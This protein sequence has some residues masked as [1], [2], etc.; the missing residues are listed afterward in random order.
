MVGWRYN[1]GGGGGCGRLSPLIM[2]VALVAVVVVMGD[3]QQQVQEEAEYPYL[4]TF[5]IMNG[6]V[7]VIGEGQ[8]GFIY[9]FANLLLPFR[10]TWT[11]PDGMPLPTYTTT[12]PPSTGVGGGVDGGVGEIY[13]VSGAYP[14]PF[15]CL[16]FRG[17]STHLSGRYMCTL[18]YGN[19]RLATRTTHLHFFAPSYRVVPLPRCF[20]VPRGG[21]VLLPS[22]VQGRPPRPPTWTLLEG[23]QGKHTDTTTNTTPPPPCN[24]ETT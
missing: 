14:I 8:N 15:A 4:P 5:G 9:C 19:T 6:S 21:T 20:L 16:V 24:I 17:F 3:Q 12:D 10:V 7:S 13:V 18:A 22:P 11:D 23:E 1:K 2:M